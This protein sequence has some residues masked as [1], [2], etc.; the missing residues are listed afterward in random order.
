MSKGD[1]QQWLLGN[2]GFKKQYERLLIESVVS[3]FPDMDRLATLYDTSPQET[4]DWNYLLLCASLLAQSDREACQDAALR[5]AH[6]CM[7]CRHSS[8]S[9]RLGAAVILDMLANHLAVALA[10]ERNLLQASYTDSLPFTLFQDWTKR[11]IENS[12]TLLNSDFLPVNRFQ[13]LFW[14]KAYANDW[15]S[16][17]APTSAGKS[18]IVGYWLAEYLRGNPRAMVV[19]LVPTRALIQQVQRDIEAIIDRE[20]ILDVA[21]S[22]L[23]TGSSLAR[24]VAHVFI[25]T[26]E[27]FHI[28]LAE[29]DADVSFDLLIVDEAHKVGDDYRGV[30]LQQAIESAIIRN[31]RCKVFFASPMTENPDILLEDAPPDVRREPLV[32]ED[33]VVNQN[34]I[35]AS[36]AHGDSATWNVELILESNPVS[37]GKM[38]LPARPSSESKRLTFVAFSMSNPRGGNVI[39]V[40]GAAEA[41]KAAMQIY[42]LAGEKSSLS[43]DREVRDLIEMVRKTIHPEYRLANV[44]R[45]GV[46]FHYGNMPLLVRTEIERLFRAN[47]IR[48][49]VC[50]STLIEG[51][52]MPCQS[53]F[54]RGPTTGRGKPMTHSDFWNL[55]G[56]A[57]RWGKEFQGNVICIDPARRDVWKQGAPRARTKFRISRTADEVLHQATDLLSFIDNRTPR[58]QAIRNPNL[59]YVFSYLVCSHILYGTITKASWARRFSD[60]TIRALDERITCIVKDL[61]TPPE[62]VLRNP[63]ISPLAMDDLLEYFRN[64]IESRGKSVEELI[65]VPPESE[66][67]VNEYVKVLH[68]ISRHLGGAFGRG[69]RVQQ[70]A[71]LIVDWMRGY[72][73]ARIIASRVKYY[74]DESLP[75]L[76]RSTM[77]DVEE[78]ARFQ[79]P[80]YLACYVDL[81]RVYLERTRRHDLMDR[82]LRLNV[83]L[84]FGVCQ[85]TQLSLIG[86]G[87]SRSSA[88]AV[89]EFI[90]DDS[91]Q[92]SQ[93]LTWLQENDWMTKDMPELIKREISNLLVR[94]KRQS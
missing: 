83:L 15:V 68:R 16:V 2:P 90:S 27:R 39:Y 52:N 60:E 89:S 20:G 58:D 81:V 70:L 74:G 51:V 4:H 36:E 50:T 28:L 78:F 7:E 31:P 34:L 80:K 91:L 77:D 45:R 3:Q 85:T 72:P 73:L 26:Q 61:S 47:K 1:L 38:R 23:P 88:I 53:I 84:E 35:W 55:S 54:V 66:E 87:L 76:I 46:A 40:N 62:I 8:E 6:Y 30:L 21:V 44:L 79:A 25:F 69:K 93:C 48:Y 12:V 64:R 59:E 86:L 33:T 11:S 49:L 17:S 57:G 94:K 43:D 10:Q 75:R 32:S 24:D 92:E 18:F 13:R 22:T 29:H 9:H 71:L 42:D 37:I 67:A 63:G 5:I 41:E 14:E 82:L 65:P 56:R 19:Y